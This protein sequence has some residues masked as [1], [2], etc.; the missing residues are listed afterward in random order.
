MTISKNTDY[1]ADAYE[2]VS[3]IKDKVFHDTDPE[4]AQDTYEFLKSIS[5][6]INLYRVAVS[7]K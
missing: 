2:A 1:L 5:T 4:I 3:K 6:Q 7:K